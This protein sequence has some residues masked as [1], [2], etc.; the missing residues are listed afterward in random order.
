[1]D[2][3][4]QAYQGDEP[5]LFVSYSHEDSDVVF[6]EIQWLKDRGFNIWYDEGISPG[7]RWSDELATSLQN[8]A[9]FLYFG[10]PRSVDSQHCQDEINLAL[11]ADKPTIAVYL[12]ETELTPGLK[13][14]LSS[15]QAILK[16][17]V[18]DQEYRDKLISG[19]SDY[20]KQSAKN[21]QPVAPVS[22]ITNNTKPILVAGGFIAIAILVGAFLLYIKPV[23]VS[24]PTLTTPVSEPVTGPQPAV[25]QIPEL[26]EKGPSIAV[27][28]FV[29]MSS[30]PEQA[31]FSDGIAEEILNT[32]VKTNTLPVIARTSSFKFRGEDF[33]AT[34]IG[35]KLRV[36]HLLEGSVRKS[37]NRV[38]ITA[39]L[40]DTTT[41]MHLWSGSY[42]RDI[43]DIFAVQ[44]EIAA[45]IVSQIGIAIPSG[46]DNLQAMPSS[47]GTANPRAYELYLRAKHL[48]NTGNPYEVEKAI[49]LYEQAVALDP[50]FADAWVDLGATYIALAG[51]PLALLIPA[52]VNPIA[53]R[54]FRTALEIDPGHTRAMGY[55]GALLINHEYQWHEGLQLLEQSVTM[56]PQDAQVLSIYGYLLY[57]TGHPDATSVLEKAYLLNPFGIYIVLM[58]ATQ[59]VFDGRFVDG[60]TL[61]ETALIQNRERYDTNLLAAQFNALIDRF[62]IAEGYLAKARAVVGADYPT[63]KAV[64]L[65]IAQASGNELRAN[66]LKTELLNLA[67]HTRVGLLQELGYAETGWDE[68]Q[69]TQVLDIALR[70]RYPGI[71]NWILA[72]PK[73]IADADWVRFQKVTRLGEANITTRDSFNRSDEEKIQLRSAAIPMTSDELDFYVGVFENQEGLQTSIEIDGNHLRWVGPAGNLQLVPM[74][75]HRFDPLELKASNYFT[76]EDGH[77]TR[78]EFRFRQLTRIYVKKGE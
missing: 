78:L 31:Y 53:I 47:K 75:S 20:V 2:R 22:S 49:P 1:M 41:G 11:D 15:H 25:T 77:I 54:A 27:L 65:N 35:E 13:L 37:G 16:H 48:A 30:D 3:P 23:Q 34:E 67:E 18:S 59:L 9:L 58:R 46:Q 4:F 63:I 36:S 52:E 29:N 74:G 76:V 56:N 57:V 17:E 45:K 50:A 38:R 24:T 42:N 72:K 14:R 43:T 32:L 33:D 21:D 8:S 66:E 70:H 39:Q 61:M 71:L 28:P 12:Q 62:D 64:D 51:L 19:I 5:Y 73:Q 6:P 26:P 60:A 40:V 10:T 55:L 68:I 7:S 69:L 44:V